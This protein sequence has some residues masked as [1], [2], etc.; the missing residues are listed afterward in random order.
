MI[1]PLDRIAA[2]DIAVLSLGA[3]SLGYLA[4]KR[5]N[6]A[7]QKTT[8]N[9]TIHAYPPGPPVRPLI[10]SMGSFPKDHLYRHFSEWADTYGMVFQSVDP[11]VQVVT[12][13]PSFFFLIR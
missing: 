6:I 5:L 10:G 3:A 2:L 12:V 9:H 13:F 11:S 4:V 8:S 1:G 7:L